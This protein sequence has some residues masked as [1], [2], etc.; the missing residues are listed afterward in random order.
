MT[1]GELL[2]IV[3]APDG[4]VHADPAGRNNGRGAYLCYQATCWKK[5]LVRRILER[6]L[7]SPVSDG[8]LDSLK[9][10]F[11]ETV[12][13]GVYPAGAGDVLSPARRTE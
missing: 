4:S 2:R 5:G 7:R 1:K 9:R 11:I 13:S 10:Y 8:D 12:A 6:K 3:R